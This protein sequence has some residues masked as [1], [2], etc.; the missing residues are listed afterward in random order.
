[1]GIGVSTAVL[2]TESVG[3]S[4]KTVMLLT[5]GTPSLLSHGAIKEAAALEVEKVT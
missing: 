4:S 3:E 5:A 1:M 2:A